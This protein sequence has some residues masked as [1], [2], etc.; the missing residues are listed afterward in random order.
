[1]ARFLFSCVGITMLSI[2][3]AFAGDLPMPAPPA[4]N[5]KSGAPAANEFTVRIACTVRCGDAYQEAAKE[6]AKKLNIPKL[7]FLSLMDD[8]VD[9]GN[10]ERSFDAVISPGGHDILPEYFLAQGQDTPEKISLRGGM[11]KRYYDLGLGKTSEKGKLRD[12]FEHQFHTRYMKDGKYKNIPMLGICYGMQMM[13]AVHGLPIYVDMETELGIPAQRKVN[14]TIQPSAARKVASGSQSG[15]QLSKL[16]PGEFSGYKNHH[17]SLH[18]Q[19]WLD[20]SR[21]FPGINITAASHDGKIAEVLE[22]PSRPYFGLQFHPERSEETTKLR[23]FGWLLR[24]GCVNA[25]RRYPASQWPA[26]AKAK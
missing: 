14:N 2:S 26:C 22:V 18:Y 6:A 19:Y 8:K 23:F 15:S 20:H 4:K 17:Q 24:K 10:P 13:G 11:R 3:L 12:S 16:L 21:E 7:Q 1:M 25:A 9:L 5:P